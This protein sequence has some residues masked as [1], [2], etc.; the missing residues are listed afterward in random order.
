MQHC[1]SRHGNCRYRRLELVRHV[2]DEIHEPGR[3]LFLPDDGPE[4]VYRTADDDAH[5]EHSEDEQW[6]DLLEY[7]YLLAREV[8]RQL[9]ETR[10]HVV[11]EEARLEPGRLNLACV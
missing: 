2:V 11:R 1:F 9:V 10:Q 6:A 7:E 5:E 8:E 3:E 4:G